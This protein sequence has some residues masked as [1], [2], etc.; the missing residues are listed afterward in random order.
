MSHFM[1]RRPGAKAKWNRHQ[2]IA[3][4]KVRS[5]AYTTCFT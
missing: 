2:W 3:P 5:A 4:P 1:H